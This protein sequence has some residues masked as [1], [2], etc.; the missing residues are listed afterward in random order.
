MSRKVLS[1]S[2]TKECGTKLFWETIFGHL[3][4]HGLV[5]YDR[6]A[7][8]VSLRPDF[9]ILCYPV[10]I[11]Q[12]D[13]AHAG[14]RAN[15]LG[16]DPDPALLAEV[17]VDQLVTPQ[18]PPC[19]L[20]QTGEDAGVPVENSLIF[21]AALRRNHVPFELHIYHKGRHGLGLNADFAWAEDCLR[22]IGQQG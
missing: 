8:S 4:A 16:A 3:A 21:A 19:F 1:H 17:A 20:W 11:M 2:C 18:T 7:S 6:Y 12:G 15:L 22:W 14:S 13:Y 9:G 10:I 5:A